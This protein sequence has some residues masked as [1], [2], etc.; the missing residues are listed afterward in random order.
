MTN[1]FVAG[2]RWN[3][4]PDTFEELTGKHYTVTLKI[5]KTKL[6]TECNVYE[7]VEIVE[8]F[9]EHLRLNTPSELSG[10]SADSFDA[11]LFYYRQNS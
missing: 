1:D 2:S 4:I 5:S 3:E 9:E 8:G 6:G 11:K 10:E 7:A